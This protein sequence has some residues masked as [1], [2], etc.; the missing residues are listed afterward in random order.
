[1][2]K[3][4]KIKNKNRVLPHPQGDSEDAI[5]PEIVIGEETLSFMS[6]S[7]SWP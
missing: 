2:E 3:T 5:T 1:L 7:A 4:L 6:P